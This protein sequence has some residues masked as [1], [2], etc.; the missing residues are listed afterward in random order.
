MDA[1]DVV[2]IGAG[3][4]GLRCAVR[5][6]ESGLD[7]VVLEAQDGVGGRE[8]TDVVDGFQLDRGFHVLNPAYPAVKRW[9]DVADLRMRPF[10]VGVR[11]RRDSGSVELRHPV[12]HPLSLPASLSSG[13]L[14]PRD[15]AALVRWVTPV[16]LRPRVVIAGTDRTLHNGW[17]RI[18]LR[19][20]LRTEVLEPF[21]AGVLADDRGATSESFA[22]LLVRMFILGAPGLPE[23]GI[24]ALPAQLAR[25]ATASGAEVRVEARV[26]GLRSRNGT[27]EVEVEHRDTVRARAVVVAVGPEAVAGLLDLPR[28]TTK[29]LQT[30]WFAADSAPTASAMLAVDGCRNG[31]VVNTVVI[32]NAVPSY[33]PPGSHL[34]E[35]TCLLPDAARTH[36]DAAPREADVRRQ[37]GEIWGTDAAAWQ[38]LRRD[39]IPDAL[40]AQPPPLHTRQTVRVGDGIFVA[41]DHRDTASIQGALVSGERAARSVL[42][43]L[44][45]RRPN[46]DGVSA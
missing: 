18:G 1:H 2:I 23:A 31:P 15:T 26:R 42:A 37:L 20:P 13:L 28:P 8:R 36:P 34:I 35:A 43:E 21:L 24:G 39:D 22:R 10:P 44:G 3:L 33:A 45:S 41:G 6:A 30:W 9:V 12:R 17:N 32:S 14:T 16:L 19:G 40:P 46:P 4:A 5:L 11:V 29:G 27:V 25:S 38:L 7:V